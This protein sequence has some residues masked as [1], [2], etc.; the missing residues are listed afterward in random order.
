MP[1]GYLKDGFIYAG[2][3]EK[4]DQRE[5]TAHGFSHATIQWQSSL[6]S[7]DKIEAKG[8]DDGMEGVAEFDT[9]YQ[10]YK[11]V[12]VNDF[13]FI[14]CTKREYDELNFLKKDAD[15]LRKI[16]AIP[17]KQP[18][19][20]PGTG[21]EDEP[22]SFGWFIQDI[23]LILDFAISDKEKLK[24]IAGK[25]TEACKQ[26][27]PVPSPSTIEA[28]QSGGDDET[29]VRLSRE[30][31]KLISEVE[32]LR[33]THRRREEWLRG[34]KKDAGAHYNESFDNVWKRCL[35]AYLAAS[36]LPDL[37]EV[38]WKLRRMNPYYSVSGKEALVYSHNWVEACDNLESIINTIK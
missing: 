8:F 2:V 34:A 29:I 27:H 7:A 18:A 14:K 11:E 10:H 20:I 32:E 17:V 21:K 28:D 38:V 9:E 12:G 33:E 19:D 36:S 22:G 24:M 1:Q 4:P 3:G 15:K 25:I 26:S 6:S 35:D 5:Y 23:D 13:R 37:K 31:T 16:V 30:N